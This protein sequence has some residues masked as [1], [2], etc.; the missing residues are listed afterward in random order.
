MTEVIEAIQSLRARSVRLSVN[1]DTIRVSYRC[2]ASELRKVKDAIATIRTNKPEAIEV[3]QRTQIPVGAVLIAPRYN[4]DSKPLTS[5]PKCWCCGKPYTLDRLQESK[6]KTYAWLKPGCGCLDA[7]TCYRC[8]ACREHCRCQQ[9]LQK[10]S[11]TILEPATQAE[12]RCWHCGS[13]NGETGLCGCSTCGHAGPGGSRQIG[14]CL[15]CLALR[16][17]SSNRSN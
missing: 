16:E 8:F 17:G 10:P 14:D 4:G 2:R 11:E 6:G 9:H 12:Q 7:W 3:L 15:A 13:K 1:G 5:V